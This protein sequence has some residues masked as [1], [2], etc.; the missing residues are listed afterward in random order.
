MAVASKP[1]EFRR[2]L[3]LDHG[4]PL[5]HSEGLGAEEE[6]RDEPD[7]VALIRQRSPSFGPLKAEDLAGTG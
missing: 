1:R 6:F 5:E 3:L 7:L 2:D 4:I